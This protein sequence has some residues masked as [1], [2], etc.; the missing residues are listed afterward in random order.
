MP[1]YDP[2]Q[3]ILKAQRLALQE[4]IR[5]KEEEE[6]RRKQMEE[7]KKKQEETLTWAI[8]EIKM[9]L[10]RFLFIFAHNFIEQG[11]VTPEE[12]EMVVERAGISLYNWAK[13]D[14]QVFSEAVY[15][16]YSMFRIGKTLFSDMKEQFEYYEKEFVGKMIEI[17]RKLKEVDLY[18]GALGVTVTEDVRHLL[19][20]GFA[21]R[22]NGSEEMI[23]ELIKDFVECLK[24]KAKKPVET[25]NSNKIGR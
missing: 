13:A 20:I 22:L 14:P 1:F 18:K 2:E 12:I 7:F 24:D 3:A 9:L 15:Q 5:R 25:N 19:E 16:L 6:R 10:R 11:K 23:N 8:A 21:S 17:I 4:E